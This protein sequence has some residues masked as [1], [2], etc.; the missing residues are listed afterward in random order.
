V[1]RLPVTAVAALALVAACSSPGV[2]KTSTP[3]V[4]TD[5]PQHAAAVRSG[6]LRLTALSGRCGIHAAS[7]THALLEPTGQFCRLRIRAASADSSA[8]TFAL[9]DQRLRLADGTDVAP[10]SGPMD[11]KR[12][13]D[14][15]TLGAEDLVE[16]VVWWDIPASAT[17]TGVTLVGD[18]DADADGGFVVPAVNPEGVLVPL[19]GMADAAPRS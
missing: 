16:V 12:Q 8:H 1:L 2:R 19:H 3:A 11:V 5:V 9:Y 10:A 17:A 7:G 13:P 4:A 18:H 14:G 15:V 6:H